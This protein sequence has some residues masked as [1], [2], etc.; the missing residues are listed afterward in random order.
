MQQDLIQ[1]DFVDGTIAM[2]AIGFTARV[3]IDRSATD[4]R[5]TL[6]ETTD[7][8]GCGAPLHR[9]RSQSKVYHVVTG[10]YLFEMDGVRI[11][12]YPGQTV[13]AKAGCTHRFV[14]IGDVTSRMLILFTPGLDAGTFFG[15]LSGLVANGRPHP[16]AMKDFGERWDVEFA[17]SAPPA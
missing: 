6:I 7:A 2:P 16:H 5:A 8:P 4:G 10:R 1:T 3:C 13:V 12:A 11:L 15:E 17:P 14:N 9:H